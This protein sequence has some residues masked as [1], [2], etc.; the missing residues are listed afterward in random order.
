[1]RIATYTRIS[2]DE[3]N[4]P[5]SLGAQQDRLDAYCKSQDAWRVVARYSDQA[6]GAS[7]EREGLQHALADATKGV[8]ELLL[9]H[10]VDRLSR[11]V[12]QLAQIS[13]DLDRASVA[14]RSAT[15]PFDTSSAAG[16]MM[17]QMLG[18]FAE[19]ERTTIVERITAG[20]D[21]AA[22]EGRW[23]V[24]KVPYGYVRDKET[25]LLLPN[26]AQALVVRRIF[27]YYVE[28][29]LGSE[30]IAQLLNSEGLATNTGVPFSA[31]TIIHMLSNPIYVGKVVFKDNTYPGLHEALVDEDTFTAGQKI[32][33]ER[34][35]SQA[36]KR[37]HPADYL[38]SGVVRC[39]QCGRAFIGTSAKGRSRRYHY[40][41][42]ST[43]YRYG[44]RNCGADR[45]PKDEL[46]EAV[47]EQ[48]IEVYRDSDLIADALAQ[49]ESSER[50]E[51][52]SIEARVAVLRQEHAGVKRSM[53]PYFAAFE[54]GTMKPNA[55]QERLDG[56]QARLDTLIAEEHT[57]MAQEE[58]ETPPTPALVAE[59]A[60]SLDVA[61]Y[62]GSAQQRKALIRKL[63]KELRVMGRD[64]IIP[65]YR[66][67]ALVRAPG[68]QVDPAGIEPATSAGTGK[69][70][71]GERRLG[72]AA[73]N[74]TRVLRSL[75]RPSTSVA[76]GWGFG[77]CRP[78]NSSGRR[79]ARRDVPLGAPSA[80]QAVSLL[81]DAGSPGRRRSP[82]PA[83]LL[84]RQRVRTR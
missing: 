52:D 71:L 6:S 74:R 41:T 11:N 46:E 76:R 38:L 78:A 59:W 13:E 60:Q 37:G 77:A 34:G 70:A 26:E 47:L 19:F 20:M 10:R 79:L 66:V 58:A 40:Y 14:L 84:V 75:G 43:R 18:V 33:T 82:R 22:S 65:T 31:R 29:Q 42:C 49:L 4:Q 81:H 80:P 55:C 27:D 8:Y 68:D 39:G 44:T 54:G 28:D 57:L 73:G 53:D 64:E 3:D 51:R 83:S 30:A 35:E 16:K 2:T 36:L 72:G 48:M 25:K 7:L 12:R 32:L 56:L 23:V 45:L 1:M 5:F 9:V 63:V 24:G 69:G 17:M 61:L 67:P 50:D 15:E 21:R 62:S